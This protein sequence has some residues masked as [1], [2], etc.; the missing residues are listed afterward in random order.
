M[1]KQ[2]VKGLLPSSSSLGSVRPKLGS[3]NQLNMIMKRFFLWLLLLCF[4]SCCLLAAQTTISHRQHSAK[5]CLQHCMSCHKAGNKK[6]SHTKTCLCVFRK[7][8]NG[9]KFVAFGSFTVAFCSLKFCCKF[10]A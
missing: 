8:F 10:F 4:F 9:L 7:V 2:L 3:R 5:N 1:F 6:T